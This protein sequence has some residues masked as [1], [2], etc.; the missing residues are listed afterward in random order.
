MT[1]NVAFGFP[2]RRTTRI[3]GEARR[4][5]DLHL[6]RVGESREAAF[7]YD[8]EAAAVRLRLSAAVSRYVNSVAGRGREFSF[9]RLEGTWRVT[10]AA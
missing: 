3:G 5:Y 6:L 4:S 1:A 8:L 2:R 10:R 9:E 7:E